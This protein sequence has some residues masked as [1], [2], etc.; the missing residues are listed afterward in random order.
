MV[1][2]NGLKTN[3]EWDRMSF[4][5]RERWLAAL[6]AVGVRGQ[7]SV[8][9]AGAAQEIEAVLLSWVLA[10]YLAYPR[11]MDAYAARAG[12]APRPAGDGTACDLCDQPAPTLIAVAVAG[13]TVSLC[14]QCAGRDGPPRSPAAE[15]RYN[16]GGW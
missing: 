16:R 10:G 6:D 5:D 8:R 12:E 9:A 3:A 14:P 13:A 7:A 11:A 15:D 2:T 4:D 1:I